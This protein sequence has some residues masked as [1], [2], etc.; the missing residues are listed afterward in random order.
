MKYIDF[1]YVRSWERELTPRREK[2]YSALN[3]VSGAI[4]R[5][6]IGELY[7]LEFSQDLKGSRIFTLYCEAFI[8]ERETIPLGAPLSAY[9]E[10]LSLF[11]R[12]GEDLEYEASL[13]ERRIMF[14]GDY[15]SL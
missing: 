3:L 14:M 2:R 9:T 10:A 11:T 15:P 12:W 13:P 4:Y 8:S 1:K 6:K 5:V 7:S